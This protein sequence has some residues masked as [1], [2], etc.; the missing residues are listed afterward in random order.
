MGSAKLYIGYKEIVSGIVS[1]ISI[2]YENVIALCETSIWGFKGK[3]SRWKLSQGQPWG[4]CDKEETGGSSKKTIKYK[5]KY[6]I[7]K[8]NTIGPMTEY[9][10]YT[11]HS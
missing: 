11:L 7:F 6:F 1:S 10:Q 4:K 5:V 3:N 9:E 2:T 8:E